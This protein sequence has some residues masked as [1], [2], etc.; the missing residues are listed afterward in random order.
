[1]MGFQENGNGNFPPDVGHVESA[2]RSDGDSRRAWRA[3]QG[4]ASR[5]Y[6]CQDGR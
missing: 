5:A 6:V 2:P 4:G 1:M 3:E